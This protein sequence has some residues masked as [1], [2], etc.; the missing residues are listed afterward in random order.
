MWKKPPL[1]FF[2]YQ[3][4]LFA[5]EKVPILQLINCIVNS[6]Y[7]LGYNIVITLLYN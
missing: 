2:Y 1:N 3:N 5:G 6:L 7:G 4:F